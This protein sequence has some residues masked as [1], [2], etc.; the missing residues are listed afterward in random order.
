MDEDVLVF[1]L[2]HV[3]PLGAHARHVA[4]DV[5]RLLVLHA[6]QHGIDHDEAA[7]PAHTRTVGWRRRGG[8]K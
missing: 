8:D 7:S 1:G 3:V 4:I 2:D 6:F 5:Y